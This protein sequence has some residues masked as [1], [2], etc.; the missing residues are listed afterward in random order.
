MH[1]MP[2]RYPFLI[3]RLH[4]WLGLII[5]IQFLAWVLGGL[6]FAWSELDEVH[7]DYE[8]APPALFATAAAY[9]PPLAVL[10]SLRQREA[11]D[12]LAELR[13]VSILGRPHWLAGYFPL[14][15]GRHHKKWLL[16]DALTGKP[17][18][19]LSQEEAVAVAKNGYAGKGAVRQVEYLAETGN[20]HEYRGQPLPAYA[21]AFDDERRSTVY[22]SAELGTVQKIR[23]RS[24]R[25]FDFLWML[26]TMDYQSRDHFGNWLLRAFSILG[27]VTVA[28]GFAL[29]FTSQTRRPR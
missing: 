19:P 2:K 28:S 14:G 25:R 17:R 18:P 4:R 15:H 21:V 26:H 8:R 13:L 12:S 27:L 1:I 9:S 24:W 29:F 7:G 3:R 11:V 10:D 6:F 22:V 16:A 5:G 23:N 20:H